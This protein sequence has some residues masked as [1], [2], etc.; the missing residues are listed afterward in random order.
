ME[1]DIDGWIFLGCKVR[2]SSNIAW[3]AHPSM[4]IPPLFFDLKVLWKATKH[5]SPHKV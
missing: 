5:T 1:G 2:T 4:Y 3:M